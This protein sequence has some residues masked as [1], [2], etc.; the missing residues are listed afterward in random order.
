MILE[1]DK[2]SSSQ[3]PARRMESIK[4]GSIGQENVIRMKRLL[5]L[6]AARILQNALELFKYSVSHNDDH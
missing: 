1:I 2:G 4:G 5:Q 3:S 6:A